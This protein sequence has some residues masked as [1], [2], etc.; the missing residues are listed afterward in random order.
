[1]NGR[2]LVPITVTMSPE[3][4]RQIRVVAAKEDKSRS[5]WVREVLTEAVAGSRKPQIEHVE[6]IGYVRSE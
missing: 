6:D 5:Q 4:A 3:L 2:I 1:M